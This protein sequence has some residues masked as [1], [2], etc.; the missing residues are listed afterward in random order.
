MTD[1]KIVKKKG[2]IQPGTVASSV[3]SKLIDKQ[4]NTA[5][6]ELFQELKDTI[7][8]LTYQAKLK[9]D[10]IPG[11]EGACQPDGGI[12]FY[13]GKPIFAS[14]SK[15]QGIGGNAIERWFDNAYILHA[16]NKNLLYLTFA[17]GDGT[18]VKEGPIWKTLHIA[19]EGDYN[20]IR[21][22][23]KYHYGLDCA[24][25]FLSLGDFEFDFVK[26]TIKTAVLKAIEYNNKMDSQRNIMLEKLKNIKEEDKELFRLFLESGTIDDLK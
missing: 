12:W 13:L 1:I 18:K 20:V 16:A 7:P 15:K 14:E 25:A 26:S 19:V 2:G 24:S 4:V 11:E 6:K 21:E 17:T 3:E 22:K 8:G 9:K 23:S 5:N 10:Q